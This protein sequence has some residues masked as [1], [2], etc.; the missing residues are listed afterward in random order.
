MLPPDPTFPLQ[1]LEFACIGRPACPIMFSEIYGRY[2]Y[3][4]HDCQLDVRTRQPEDLLRK[5]LGIV[6]L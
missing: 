6:M 4:W 2:G 1:L 3:E 5:K